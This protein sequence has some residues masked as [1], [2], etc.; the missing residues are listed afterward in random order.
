MRAAGADLR[1]SDH[2]IPRRVGPLDLALVSHARRLPT[3]LD[4]AAFGS[5]DPA[6]DWRVDAE[7]VARGRHPRGGAWFGSRP[8]SLLQQPGQ[9]P[10]LEDP[11]FGLI[12]GAVGDHV[13]LEMHR[14]QGVP[15]AG[16]GLAL[17]AMDL[18]WHRQLGG[19]RE[20]YDLLV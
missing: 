14:A 18:Q 7:S 4:D 6:T 1:A 20:G 13:V 5:P 15:A 11:A 2:G 9:P 8:G 3:R 19:D 10:V 12:G 16:A 17:V